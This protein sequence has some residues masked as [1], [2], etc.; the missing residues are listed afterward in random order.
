MKN[1]RIHFSFFNLL[2]CFLFF[3]VVVS[4]Q[5][6]SPSSVGQTSTAYTNGSPNDDIFVFCGAGNNGA[7][8]VNVS[9][10]TAPYN[11]Q[12][13]QYNATTHSWST[14]VGQISSSLMN[15]SSG[16]YAVDV[17]DYTGSSVLFDLAWVWNV[18]LAFN[19]QANLSGCSDVDLNVSIP[20]LNFTYY[21]PPPPM[22]LISN[23]TAITVCYTGSHEYVSD[24]GF[25]LRGPASC[26][27]PLISLA[28]FP[29]FN[30]NGGD[31]F[32]NLC[33][34]SESNNDFDVCWEPT[35][36]SGTFGSDFG[37]PI[38]WNALNSCN[39]SESDWSVLVY[40]CVNIDEGSLTQ[41][42]ITFSNLPS[43]NGS[44]T[45]ISYNS[46]SI[47]EPI[48]D[49]TCTAALA[50]SF[51]VPADPGLTT[52]IA[53]SAVI[54]GNWSTTSAALIANANAISTI[55]TSAF[56]GDQFIYTSTVDIGS[57]SCIFS[58][59]VVFNN[60]S[61]VPLSLSYPSALCEGN[62]T[63]SP[64]LVGSSGGQYT[65]SPSG[66]TISNDGN[67]QINTS[68]PGTYVVTYTITSAGCTQSTS[69]GITIQDIPENLT[70]SP[71]NICEGTVFN[72]DAQTAFEYEYF[73]N[74]VSQG[75]PAPSSAIVSPALAAGDDWCVRGY[76]GP[77]IVI[78]GNL[79]ESYW[80][81][82]LSAGNTNLISSFGP[83]NHMDALYV[84]QF[85]NLLAFG[86]AGQLESGSN[87]R[88]LIFLDT[89]PGGYNQLSNWI[90]RSN[91]PYYSLENLSGNIQFD[92][93]F[94]P[95]YVLAVNTGS[96]GESYVDLYH[97]ATNTNNYLGSSATPDFCS[98]VP[99]GLT[100]NV[101]AGYEFQFDL[102]E[103]NNP[104]GQISIFAMMVNNPG[105]AGIATTLSNQFLSPAD[106]GELSY[107]DG[108]VNFNLALPNPVHYVIG[109][110]NCY[111][112]NCLLIDPSQSLT[113]PT[114]P[115]QC[116]NTPSPYILNPVINGVSG[117]WS[118]TAIDVSV[119]GTNLYAFTPD[120]T[121]GCYADGTVSV[122]VVD[123]IVPGFAI[124]NDYCQGETP[125]PLPLSDGVVSG[126]WSPVSISTNV[127]ATAGP[128]DYLFTPNA[129]QCASDFTLSVTV[130]PTE[131]PVFSMVTSLC[132]NATAP[133]LP[134]IDDNGIQ[135]SWSGSLNTAN[136]GLQ[137]L[138]FIP[139]IDP[140]HACAVS[141]TVN[142]NITNGTTSTF[143][144]LGPFCETDSPSLPSTSVEGFTGIWTPSVI[145]MNNFNA[146]GQSFTFQPDPNQCASPG[147]LNVVVQDAV[148]AIF[149]FATTYC[150]GATAS[151]LPSNSQN[152]FSG[153]WL[154]N[155]IVTGNV[156]A[157][158]YIFTPDVA[159][160]A[161]IT[162]VSVTI[163]APIDPTFNLPATVC[164][165]GVGPT[166]PVTSSNA[167][168]GTWSPNVVNTAITGVQNFVFTH[169]PASCA[170]DYNYSI[171]VVSNQTPTFNVIGPFCINSV[172]PGLPIN[173]NENIAGT[174]NPS[175]INTAS[176]GNASYTFT[177]SA[178]V[179]A[180]N[181]TIQV[182]IDS[183]IIPSFTSI[184]ALCST[185]SAPLLPNSSNNGITGNWNLGTVDMGAIG[186]N[187]YTFTADPNQCASNGNL[188]IEV[189][190]PVNPLF[191]FT[192]NYC[193]GDA[194]DLLPSISDDLISG[195]WSPASIDAST[196]SSTNFS[197]A[198]DAGQCANNVSVPVLINAPLDAV[199]ASAD[200]D[201]CLNE[202]VPNLPVSEDG[203]MVGTWSP[204]N[205]V[206]TSAGPFVHTFTPNI[207]ECG[208]PTD[209]TIVVND[210]IT[211]VISGF[212]AQYCL[213]DA[214]QLLPNTN[215]AN[216]PGSWNPAAV[217]TNTVGL[218]QP[219]I[220]TPN[221][222]NCYSDFTLSV[223]VFDLPTPLFSFSD[224]I[225]TCNIPLVSITAS[226]GVSYLWS[227]GSTSD[228][229]DVFNSDALNV[230]VTDGNGCVSS[231]SISVPMDTSTASQ[232]IYVTNELNCL[233]TSIDLSVVGGQSYSWTPNGEITNQ[234]T[235]TV[236]DNYSVDILF[237]NGCSRILDLD[238]V[239][240]TISPIGVIQ[241]NSPS[242]ILTCAMPTI[243]LQVSGGASYQWING[244][245]SPLQNI[246]Q[247]GLVECE[248]TGANF[249]LDTVSYEIFQ[250]IVAPIVTISSSHPEFDCFTSDITL[251]AGG[252]ATGYTW[253]NGLGTNPVINC[254]QSGLY[255]VTG[256][257]ANGCSTVESFNLSVN[258]FYPDS[259]FTYSPLEIWDDNPTIS[260]DG[261]DQPDISY[262]WSVNGEVVYDLNNV[263]FDLPSFTHGD[264]EI[265]LKAY[266]TDICQSEECQIVSI[267]ES[268][269]IY[270]PTSFTPG[271]DGI[272]DGYRPVFSNDEMLESYQMEIFNRWG[273]K[274]FETDNPNRGWD[275]SFMNMGYF[276]PDGCYALI[277]TYRSVLSDEKQIHKGQITFTR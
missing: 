156:G 26:G 171:D 177:P 3:S 274:V 7:L 203:G 95:D 164:E 102:A 11:Y 254:N 84:S 65:S 157:S 207:G 87:N 190:S 266:F 73:L 178:G 111:L 116:L 170:T 165:N 202:V 144:A 48:N 39:A 176:V 214:A 42:S 240:D 74:G 43:T 135:G 145:D 76:Q 237:N 252:N 141:S 216:I 107:G 146:A 123:A 99:A 193:V 136:L 161:N 224:P 12:W 238:I 200:F 211:S 276:V 258:R 220:F 16:G 89:E 209:F 51:D 31:D 17:K 196:A 150:Q 180:I 130:S 205:V 158:N 243:S 62:N 132:Q 6:T 72:G 63:I 97:M 242:D 96:S 20:N 81:A 109:S 21:N 64:I 219:Y 263:T 270:I 155:S 129:N 36:L 172:A 66:L 133:A 160:C 59:D 50:S 90:N 222:G 265:C 80:G 13:Y 91:A 54:S 25:F 245:G 18:N 264:F 183:Q 249:C 112:E 169:N 128:V 143:A 134:S 154:P 142:F 69:V 37:T 52:P 8:E 215:D 124:D 46:G 4:G 61:S 24:L 255:S 212:D 259:N 125:A 139:N 60:N 248:V 126:S 137:P 247:P 268:F 127:A 68:V 117:V 121:S 236:P 228:I 105:S 33:F 197:F 100:F 118:P 122:Q 166:L 192:T 85:Q 159:N 41:A 30:C 186:I 244:G 78:D 232:L 104:Q 262:Y 225:I 256:L 56:D 83:G 75:P 58:D 53:L 15:L 234:I 261:P 221:P 101:G 55:A 185:D 201:F 181:Q 147:S 168:S 277:I 9:S 162:S 94:E 88:L 114:I 230:E 29:G 217:Q 174:W 49:G 44:P 151:N 229:V 138:I 208:N 57:A 199:F 198:V 235:V 272:N 27:S 267:K 98:Y 19:A 253:A 38:Q 233:L 191:S 106:V 103:L 67:I 206:T 213:N 250:D 110:G 246:T 167:I 23:N 194:T 108:S 22:V 223:D 241:N 40:D 163:N 148:D 82:P 45:T 115:D 218:N 47:N 184:P 179:C 28:Q 227:D 5:I 188:D 175:T 79:T 131:N 14:M 226:G 273:E 195:V 251:T 152:G 260:L 269:Q 231:A 257:A 119:V 32:L 210:P 34:S 173:S 275:G 1:R 140:L 189:V 71:Q 86:I 93:G 204:S 35:P 77:G 92:A 187:A 70:L 182:T 239:Q 149:N 10:G 120:A 113:L 2:L 271:S 153:F